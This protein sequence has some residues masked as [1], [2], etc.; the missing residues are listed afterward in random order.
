MIRFYIA[1]QG[2]E[3]EQILDTELKTITWTHNVGDSGAKGK[4]TNLSGDPNPHV[5]RIEDV[6]IDVSTDL[7]WKPINM[8][9]I[10]KLQEY[11]IIAGVP[12]K[13]GEIY[14]DEELREIADTSPDDWTYKDGFI[15]SSSR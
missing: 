7:S 9:I 5:R 13:E 10:E 12:N 11:I 2:T 14:T 8:E 3:N 1:Y 6:N 4:L 15:I